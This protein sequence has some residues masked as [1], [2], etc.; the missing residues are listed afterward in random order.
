M[1][2][3]TFPDV[4]VLYRHRLVATC[5]DLLQRLHTSLKSDHHP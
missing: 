4:D 5:S 3:S 1:S 2:L